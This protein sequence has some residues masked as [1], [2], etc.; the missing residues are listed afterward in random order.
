MFVF[1]LKLVVQYTKYNFVNKNVW[2]FG[3]SYQRWIS[4]DGRDILENGCFSFAIYTKIELL[5]LIEKTIQG[6]LITLGV[7]DSYTYEEHQSKYV[8][9]SR[10]RDLK[11]DDWVRWCQLDCSTNPITKLKSATEHYSKQ[12]K[13]K[14]QTW[15]NTKLFCKMSWP[16]IN[17]ISHVYW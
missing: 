9:P 7:R 1:L 6:D 16:E 15:N 10:L 4:F 3:C 12:S 13:Q 8:Y 14:S 11:T 2:N 17:R 5:L